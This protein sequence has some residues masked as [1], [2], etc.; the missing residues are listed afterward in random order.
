MKAKTNT[1][2]K[3]LTSV[4]KRTRRIIRMAIVPHKKND[5]RP[6]LIRRYGLVAMSFAVI[7]MQFGYNQALTGRVLGVKTEITINELLVQTNNTRVSYGAGELKLNEKLNQAAILKAK[8]MFADQ[9]W[10][11]VAPDGTQ[12]W[13][14]FGDVGYNYSEAGENLAKNFSTTSATMTAWMNSVGHRANVLNADYTEVGFA[15]LDG[16]MDG[17]ATS[18]VVALYGTPVESTVAGAS[19]NF[20][21]PDSVE[22]T[23]LITRAAIAIQSMTSASI[24]GIA[25]IVFATVVAG[26]SHAYRKKLPKKFRNSWYRH[27]GVIKAA[28]LSVFGLAVMFFYSG[29]QI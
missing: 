16:E 12:P 8:D 13:K 1:S 25:L 11:H 10:A 20:L 6:H 27:H 22:E 26:M 28:G 29:G 7:G 24:V 21:Q 4:V 15:V 19:T 2:K 3:L 23:S 9:Y 14:W 18:L 17:K 5:Y